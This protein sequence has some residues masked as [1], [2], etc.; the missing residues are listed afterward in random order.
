MKRLL[1]SLSYQSLRNGAFYRLTG[2]FIVAMAVLGVVLGLSSDDVPSAGKLIVDSPS[3]L[4]LFQ[5]MVIAIIVG[6]VCAGDFK[7]KDLY[8]E[9]MSGHSRLNI[10]FSKAIPATVFTA[11]LATFISAVPVISNCFF[12]GWGDVIEVK[13]AVIRIALCFFPFLRLAAFFT[14][15]AFLSKSRMLVTA[16][17]YI[18]MCFG[19]VLLN[20]I[21]SH[22]S[23]LLSYFNLQDL[24][25]FGTWS[26]YNLDPSG[27]IV[28]H[29]AYD[30]S[31]SG[32][33]ISGTIIISLLVSAVY[34]IAGYGFFRKNDLD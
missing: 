17:G 21:G 3:V 32:S 20:V 7:D 6:T 12:F 27:G 23:F 29:T 18:A 1:S 13:G 8:Y 31:I 22:S 4:W 28:M 11:L 33:M 15:I 10:F 25:D 16:L 5:S 24:M 2:L 26:I 9:I 19:M 34:L 14:L 30:S